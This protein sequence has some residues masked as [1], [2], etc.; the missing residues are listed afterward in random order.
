METPSSHRGHRLRVTRPLGGADLYGRLEAVAPRGEVAGNGVIVPELV[1]VGDGVAPFVQ[2][3][4][5]AVVTEP[6]PVLVGAPCRLP[7]IPL[8]L[9][10]DL[11]P[12]IQ[13]QTLGLIPLVMAI[14]RTA[15]VARCDREASWAASV[16]CP[17]LK[18]SRFR[19]GDTLGEERHV[20][21]EIVVVEIWSLDQC[22]SPPELRR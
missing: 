10:G 19:P 13:P 3:R 9:V 18:A 22:H 14:E 8:A 6:A 7:P 4:E 17:D 2:R 20:D 16:H 1:L 12:V 21:S 11:V 15:V 5:T